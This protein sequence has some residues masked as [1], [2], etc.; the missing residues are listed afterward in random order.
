VDY[1]LI[2]AVTVLSAQTNTTAV[3]PKKTTAKKLP[4]HPRC[5]AMR[6]ALAAQQVQIQKQH[7]EV[8]EL[9]SQLQQVLAAAQGNNADLERL[10]VWL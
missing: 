4:F 6:E 5:R 7:Q 3:H 8:E 1:V 9:K 10:A 2:C